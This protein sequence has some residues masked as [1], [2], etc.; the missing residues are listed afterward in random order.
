MSFAD[1]TSLLTPC[2]TLIGNTCIIYMCCYRAAQQLFFEGTL[3]YPA[4]APPPRSR[5]S[6]Y[7]IFLSASQVH[8]F[9]VLVAIFATWT[10]AL[11]LHSGT[12]VYSYI[13]VRLF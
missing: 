4:P 1:S 5:M 2:S 8:F 3:T 10:L 7:H 9:A 12:L 11:E 6:R 13:L